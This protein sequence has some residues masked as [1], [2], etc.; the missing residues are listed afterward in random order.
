[1][2][3]GVGTCDNTMSRFY[4][5]MAI[6]SADPCEYYADSRG[7]GIPRVESPRGTH[8]QKGGRRAGTAC[9]QCHYWLPYEMMPHVGQCDNPDSRLF[10]SPAFSDKP[11]EGCFVDRSLDNLEFMW[12]QS[13]RQTIYSTELPDH[14]GCSVFVSSVSLPVEDEMELTVAGD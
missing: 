14:R 2:W 7:Q 4:A 10:R 9:V 6:G 12:C 13:H 3:E 8:E 5:R 11:T 1:M